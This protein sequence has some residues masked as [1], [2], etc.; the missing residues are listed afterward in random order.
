M[1]MVNRTTDPATMAEAKLS[2]IPGVTGEPPNTQD[3]V[4]RAEKLS[5][6]YGAISALREVS[7]DVARNSCTA[8]I[9][10]NGAGKTTLIKLLLNLKRPRSGRV[11]LNGQDITRWRTERRVKEGL[12]LVPEG[13]GLL[14]SLS[15][16]ENL[17]VGA[18]LAPKRRSERIE[19]VY[20][21]LPILKPLRNRGANHLS[22]GELQLLAIGRALMGDVSLLILDEPSMGLA[23][24]ALRTVLDCLRV[25]K[26]EGM[27]ML[28]IEQNAALAFDLA[29]YVYVLELGANALDGR[30]DRLMADPSLRAAYLGIE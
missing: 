20:E 19:R 14:P 30:P 4:L 12:R 10:S 18:Y 1:M 3:V 15:V 5:A 29:E 17:L 25:V 7:L 2:T 11:V 26:Q 21:L 23:P 6:S 28:L 22:G 16:E 8:V 27:S 9:G 13:R 24:K